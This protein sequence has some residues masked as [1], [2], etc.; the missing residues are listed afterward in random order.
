MYKNRMKYV[1]SLFLLLLLCFIKYFNET[2][3]VVLYELGFLI[4]DSALVTFNLK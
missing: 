2:F 1:Q 3:S 4:S